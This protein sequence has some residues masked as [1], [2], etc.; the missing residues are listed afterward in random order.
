MSNETILTNATLI[1]EDKLIKGT[2]TFTER[3]VTSIETGLS[4]LPAAIDV[5][6]DFIAPGIVEMHTD[7]MEKHFVPRPGVFWPNEIGR[8]HV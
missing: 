2:I 8:A 1:L 7:N 3:A 6:G 5:E 4:S